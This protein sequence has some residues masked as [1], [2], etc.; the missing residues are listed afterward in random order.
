MNDWSICI[1]WKSIFNNMLRRFKISYTTL[2]IVIQ[3]H[4]QSPITDLLTHSLINSLIDWFIHF[5]HS[6][7]HSNY[8]YLFSKNRKI[9]SS[10]ARWWKRKAQI[11]DHLMETNSFKYLGTLWKKLNNVD[12]NISTFGKLNNVDFNIS[13]FG[14]FNNIGFHKTDDISKFVKGQYQSA[15]FKNEKGQK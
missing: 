4:T 2:S 6:L 1:A 11:H 5:F 7:T 9:H 8:R 13:T 14:K 15:V 10:D 3:K 12:L